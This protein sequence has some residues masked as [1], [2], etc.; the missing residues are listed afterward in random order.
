M[1]LVCSNYT[2]VQHGKIINK[3]QMPSGHPEQSYFIDIGTIMGIK[4]RNQIRC[5]TFN[6]RDF[7]ERIHKIS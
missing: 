7:V 6:I 3:I 2:N 1:M 4:Q 5:I